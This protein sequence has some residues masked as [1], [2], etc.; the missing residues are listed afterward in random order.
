ME[1]NQPLPSGRPL[2]ASKRKVCGTLLIIFGI[3]G[4]SWSLA[5]YF[6]ES[7][8]QAPQ[9]LSALNGRPPEPR[10]TGRIQSDSIDYSGTVLS[11]LATLAL[12]AAGVMLIRAGSVADAVTAGKGLV[13]TGIVL[14]IAAAAAYVFGFVVC[15][16]RL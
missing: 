5:M 7:L 4:G 16:N 1:P 3:V 11:A 9:R 15:L 2:S 14:T 6:G 13:T 8:V 10:G 12:I